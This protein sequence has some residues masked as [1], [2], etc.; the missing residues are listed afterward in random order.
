M[1]TRQPITNK[2]MAI[3]MGTDAVKES[4]ISSTPSTTCLS[5]RDRI[6][7]LYGFWF[8]D[9]LISSIYALLG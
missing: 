4:R 5:K 2:A 8:N 3:D 6:I 1:E 7:H 9:R